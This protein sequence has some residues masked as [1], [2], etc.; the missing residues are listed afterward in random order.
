MTVLVTG[1]TGVIGSHV[2]R[3]LVADGVDVVATSS[4]GDLSL[5]PDLQGIVRVERCDVRDAGAAQRLI[6]QHRVDT[7]IHLAALLHTACAANPVEAVEVNVT[8]TSALYAACARVGVERFVYASSKGVYGDLPA[9]HRAPL[10]R[11][12][13]ED[14]MPRPMSVYDATKYAGELVLDTQAALGGPDVVSLRF[15]TIYGAG[16]LMRHGPTAVLS[17]LVEEAA[18]GNDVSFDAGGDQVDDMI[19]VA[20]AADGIVRAALAGTLRHRLYNIGTGVGITFGAFA[21][22]VAEVHPGVRIH[23]GGGLEYMGPGAVY[24]PLD[25]TRARADLGFD[26]DPDP[27]AGIRRYTAALALL[28]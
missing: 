27:G 3:R 17:L 7:V 8:A 16:K 13:R 25:I 18:A 5:I 21:R 9:E 26:P 14:V 15:A 24:G 12:V 4:R 28:A 22:S 2:L 19:Y 10:Y 11:P 6:E 23:V 20:D 1:G